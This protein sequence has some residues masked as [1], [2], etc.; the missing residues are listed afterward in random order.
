MQTKINKLTGQPVSEQTLHTLNS[1]AENRSVSLEAIRQLPEMQEAYSCISKSVPTNL[2]KN[3]ENIQAHVIEEISE[4]GSFSGIDENGSE[5]YNGIVGNDRRI[6]IVIGLPASGKSSTIVNPLSN[7]F[8]SKVIDSD[9]AKELLPEFN[10][11]WG[12]GIVHEESKYI[13]NKILDY[14]L[15][16]GTNIVYPIVGSNFNKVEQFFEECAENGYQIFVHYADIAPSKAL[17]RMLNRFFETGRFLDPAL[18][19]RYGNKVSENYQRIKEE[20]YH[21]QPDQSESSRTEYDHIGNGGT[22]GSRRGLSSSMAEKTSGSPSPSTQRKFDIRASGA[23]GSRLTVTEQ[24]APSIRIAGYSCWN[25]DVPRG[26]E[27]QLIE[28]T[29]AGQ[30]FER[31]ISDYYTKEL[32][33]NGF[34]PSASLLAH[35]AELQKHLIRLPSLRDICTMFRSL[36]L[37]PTDDVKTLVQDI[38]KECAAQERLQFQCPER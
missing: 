13:I 7:E 36:E 24:T 12:A 35:C 20:H 21:E 29:C 6:D 38:G 1:L 22:L 37:C 27:P 16:E 33:Q 18:T 2:L 19:F 34:Q 15:P 23:P 14:A 28:S 32:R 8:H 11:G 9:M 10:G 17:G 31:A 26:T 3:R 4:K 25:T 5:L 30:M